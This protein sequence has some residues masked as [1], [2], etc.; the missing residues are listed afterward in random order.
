MR[1]LCAACARPV[2]GLCAACA[3]PVRGLC[4]A[5]AQPVRVAYA[6]GSGSAF[7]AI[8]A[9]QASS[10]RPTPAPSS[11]VRMCSQAPL[12]RHLQRWQSV[13]WGATKVPS[14]VPLRSRLK[15]RLG[16]TLGVVLL[17]AANA[18]NGVFWYLKK[19]KKR[20]IYRGQ[21]KGESNPRPHGWKPCAQP[22]KLWELCVYIWFYTIND[23][24]FDKFLYSL[25]YTMLNIENL[26][27]LITF[28]FYILK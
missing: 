4:T 18:M 14:S 10:W 22:T 16:R 25:L 27:F 19:K 2:R 17:Q 28:V 11:V 9:V 20:Y 3:R 15:R 8:D 7:N 6:R 23:Y 5:C 12:R 26:P 1:G 13:L 24:D 21:T